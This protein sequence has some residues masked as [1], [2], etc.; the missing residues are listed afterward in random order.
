MKQG[1]IWR[2]N[3]NPSH[4]SEQAGTRPVVIVSGNLL[5]ANLPIVIMMP[6]TSR[7]KNYKGHPVLEPSKSNGLKAR[8]EI[9]VFH[10]RS[11]AKDRLQQKI[12]RVEPEELKQLVKTLNDILTF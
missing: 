2:A 9:L 6:L 7:I 11:V 10:V 1:E 3:L 5:N 8:S 4:G 12:G